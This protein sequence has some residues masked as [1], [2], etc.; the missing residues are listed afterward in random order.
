MFGAD[1]GSETSGPKNGAVT[2]ERRNV[3]DWCEEVGG[4]VVTENVQIPI[5]RVEGGLG[6]AGGRAR[7]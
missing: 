2:A 1:R 7:N 4:Q 6:E 3:A 5:D